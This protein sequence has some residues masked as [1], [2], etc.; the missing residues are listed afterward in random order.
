MRQCQ[1]IDRVMRTGPIE[2]EAR[3]SKTRLIGDGE[4]D[5]ARALFGRRVPFG[6]AQ[7]LNAGGRKENP[8]E[9]QLIERDLRHAQMAEVGRIEGAAEE[10]EFHDE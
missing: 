2:I 3:H 9:V 1:Q 7:R 6:L 8:I 10:A 4:F 5:H